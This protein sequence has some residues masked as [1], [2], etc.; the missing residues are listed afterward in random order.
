[1]WLIYPKHCIPISIKIGQ[2]VLNLCTKVF[3]CVFMPHGVHVN[4]VRYPESVLRARYDW[5]IA[6]S[7]HGNDDASLCIS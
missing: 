6:V 2:H 1:V 5:L 3:G 7:H 4:F